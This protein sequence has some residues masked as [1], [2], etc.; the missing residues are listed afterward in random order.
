MKVSRAETTKLNSICAGA[1]PQNVHTVNLEWSVC[2]IPFYYYYRKRMHR[3][4]HACVSSG[5]EMQ[6][7]NR[8][9]ITKL[10]VHFRSNLCVWSPCI[11]QWLIPKIVLRLAEKSSC[12]L[13]PCCLW[14]HL[15]PQRLLHSPRQMLLFVKTSLSDSWA[16][17]QRTR[18]CLPYFSSA[19]TP[20]AFSFLCVFVDLITITLV[21]WGWVGRHPLC[22]WVAPILES[23]SNMVVK[24]K[25]LSVGLSGEWNMALTRK[26]RFPRLHSQ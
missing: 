6:H 10:R 3:E 13:P 16:A 19:S 24:G 14:G 2:H 17:F 4:E 15:S 25:S 8:L 22:L 1:I 12:C 21:D 11:W 26:W 23:W 18:T 7:L 5:R 20:L 9:Q